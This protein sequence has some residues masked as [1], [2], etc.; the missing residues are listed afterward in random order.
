VLC[1]EAAVATLVGL[2][3]TAEHRRGHVSTTP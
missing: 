3:M 1:A 2:S